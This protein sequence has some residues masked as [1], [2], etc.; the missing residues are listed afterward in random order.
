M[1][2]ATAAAPGRACPSSYGYGPGV[3]ARAPEISADVLYVVGGL[4]G[5]LPALLEIERMAALEHAS[6]HIVFN[7]D[8]HWFDADPAEFLAIE[9]GVARHTALRGNVETEI[10]ADEYV[11]GCGCAYPDSVPDA[12]VERSNRILA[13]LRQAACAAEVDAPELRRR[14]ASLPMHRVAEV[15]GVRIGLVHGDA[16]ALAGWRFA[17]DALHAEQN[18]ARL[19]ALF[20]QAAVDG[21]ASSHTCLPALKAFAS[22]LGDRFIINNGAAGMP[23]FR[24]TRFGVITR[25]AAVPVPSALHTARLYG[26][27]FNGAYVDALAVRFDLRAADA[28]FAR[29]WPAASDAAQSY[30]RRLVDGPDFS[31]DDALGRSAAPA[32]V[33]LAA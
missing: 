9:H 2:R 30:G 11:N 24:G 12:D 15:A 20:E 18:T 25:I 14:L 10:A 16:W 23:N 31:I 28:C 17:H 33:A 22:P 3:F 21:F 27:E 1:K 7:G 19:S 4:Y 32:C 26:G 5:N 8:F 13:R 6:T 29:L